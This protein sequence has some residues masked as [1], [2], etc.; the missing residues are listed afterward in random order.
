MNRHDLQQESTCFRLKGGLVALTTI[1]LLNFTPEAFQRQL[2]KTIENAP[3][4]FE[5]SPVILALEKL[6]P[7]HQFIDFHS[8]RALCKNYGI[9]LVAIRGGTESHRA[10]A[11]TAGLAWLPAAK[12]KESKN[13]KITENKNDGNVILMSQHQLRLELNNNAIDDNMSEKQ[14]ATPSASSAAKVIT[15]PVRS[16]QQIHSDGDLIVFGQVSTGAELLAAGNIH[17][18]GALRGRALAGI[19]RN[20][21]ARIF[22][23]S[24]EAELV[25]IGGNY[26][27]I[28]EQDKKYWKKPFQA[29]LVE[30]KL[31]LEALS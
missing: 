13:D 11:Q 1:E 7:S 21:H 23:H 20:N 19:E 6:E 26:K 12:V 30:D 5:Q 22:C 4:F 16:G 8:L 25:S 29:Y 24:F 17:V 18:Y 14:P 9:I 15:T 10:V 27:L 28:S 3:R 31:H 2:S